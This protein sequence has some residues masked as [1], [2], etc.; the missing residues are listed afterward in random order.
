M[1]I[2]SPYSF[3]GAPHL[4]HDLGLPPSEGADEG[5]RA[6]GKVYE[7]SLPNIQSKGCW[8]ALSPLQKVDF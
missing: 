3:L 6:K 4:A 5:T 7:R 8:A 1:A 2:P